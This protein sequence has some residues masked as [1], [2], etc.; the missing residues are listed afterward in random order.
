MA[1]F[2]SQYQSVQASA[3]LSANRLAT[4]LVGPNNCPPGVT[5]AAGRSAYGSCSSAWAPSRGGSGNETVDITV[6]SPVYLTG[7]EPYEVFSPGCFSKAWVMN[8]TGI[9]EVWNGPRPT[10]TIPASGTVIDTTKQVV[11]SLAQKYAAF[12]LQ[13]TTPPWVEVDAIKVWGYVETPPALSLSSASSLTFGLLAATSGTVAITLKNSG[14]A[15]LHW[16]LASPA[17]ATGSSAP[18]VT[19]LTTSGVSYAGGDVVIRLLLNATLA[20]AGFQTV[21]L[22]VADRYATS[23]LIRLYKANLA[24]DVSSVAPPTLPA[25][26]CYNGVLVG[27]STTSGGVCMCDPG[28]YGQACEFLNCPGNC[29]S[30]AVV[31]RGVCD[32]TVG[33]CVCVPGFTGL[34]C[35]GQ[36]GDCYVSYDGA[37]YDTWSKGSYVLNA[38]DANNLNRGAGLLPRQL[39][40]SESAEQKSA[41]I[42][43]TV[44]AYGC[45]IYP[46]FEFCCRPLLAPACPYASAAPCL[47]PSCSGIADVAALVGGRS[48]EGNQTTAACLTTLI[49]YCFNNAY[50]PACRST[51]P[52]TPP[53]YCPTSLIMNYCSAS[54]TDA[55][56]VARVVAARP[57]CLFL[58]VSGT[59]CA[60]AT[61]LG[62]LGTFAP[63]CQPVIDAHCMNNPTD[64]EC[65]LHGR[66]DGCLFS[67]DSPPCTAP[68]C[69][70]GSTSYDSVRCAATS[71][72]YCTDPTGL[73]SSDAECIYRGYE[74]TPYLANVPVNMGFNSSAQCAWAIVNKQCAAAPTA[75]DCLRLR[76]VRLLPV[77]A[78]AS[79]YPWGA[80]LAS[81]LANYTAAAV[82]TFASAASALSDARQTK[83]LRNSMY[84]AAFAFSDASADGML[85]S[86]EIPLVAE[87]LLGVRLG[88]IGGGVYLGAGGNVVA[89]PAIVTTALLTEVAGTGGEVSQLRFAAILDALG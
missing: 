63:A 3:P 33:A 49:T 35:S 38:E 53:E 73:G 19:P 70:V 54:P 26:L 58:V 77:A 36:D 22:E 76:A 41:S 20:T 88:S 21:S 7:L 2:S 79:P 47:S 75:P 43:R 40:C 10:L 62:P 5:D 68:E 85:N 32:K 81:A 65:E 8:A 51:P 13:F 18:W 15:T 37:C 11:R 50:D 27:A 71:A 55:D 69:I 72:A 60:D 59:P 23:S 67:A 78:S 46:T 52:G 42:T 48:L 56:C 84:Q 31:T 16:T 39:Q 28:A 30:S 6:A 80:S 74:S 29:S 45:S 82:T 86:G 14:T 24:L 89:V 66:G 25:T 4:N 64:R 87:F 44:N 17:N 12:R 9:E 1:N 34:D 57:L 61:C 83:V